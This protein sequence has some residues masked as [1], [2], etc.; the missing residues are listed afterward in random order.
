MRLKW[1]DAVLAD[2]EHVMRLPSDLDYFAQ[3]AL[4]LRS[5]GGP[6]KPFVFNAAQRKPHEVVE[7]QK[8]KTGKVR[9]IDL[10]ARGVSTNIAASFKRRSIAQAYE[11]TLLGMRSVPAR[12]GS[13]SSSDITRTC[14]RICGRKSRRRTPQSCYSRSWIAVRSSR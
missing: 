7:Q 5:K 12:I 10:K 3:T 13:R 8:A 14:P 11:P 9:V 1:L 4:K 6:L 2:G